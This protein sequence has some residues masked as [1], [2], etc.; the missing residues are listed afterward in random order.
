MSVDSRQQVDVRFFGAHDRAWVPAAHCMLFS[1]KDPNKTKGGTP[2]NNKNASKTQKGIADAMKEKD[3]YIENLRARFGF[4]YS[5]FRQQFDP[6]ELKSQLEAMLPNLKNPKEVK[7]GSELDG[8]Q[9]EKL[10]LKII[11]GQSSNYQV[12]HKSSELRP[13]SAKEKPKLYKVH[14]KNDDNTKEIDGKLIPLIIKR[15]SNI[16]QEV[17]RTKRSRTGS[18]TSESSVSVQSAR[19]VNASRR[20]STRE[21]IKQK[22]VG[23]NNLD[24]PSRKG[25]TQTSRRKKL[26]S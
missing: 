8:L 13:P 20:K 24:P 21:P 25:N 7:E 16:E 3:D 18:E 26:M 9:K 4:K 1:E 17:D 6:N 22:K 19:M 11:K 10:T 14:S 12:E 15:K 2:A 5:P 23:K